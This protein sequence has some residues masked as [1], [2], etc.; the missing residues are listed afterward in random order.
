MGTENKK[1]ALFHRFN[2]DERGN[3][4]LMMALSTVVILSAV[5]AAVDFSVVSNADS[6]AQTI[7]DSSALAAAI[8]VKNHGSQ[9]SSKSEGPYGTYTAKELGYEVPGWVI[10]GAEGMKVDVTYDDNAK[11]AKVVVSGKTLPTFAQ[12]MGHDY[13]PFSAETTVKYYD[14]ELKDPA[15]IAL[16]LDNSGSMAWDD[17]PIIFRNNG[18]YYTPSDAVPRIDAL[19]TSAKNFMTSLDNLVGDQGLTQIG[20]RVLRTGMLA[21]NYQT[22]NTRTVHMK[23]G[24]LSNGNI[25]SMKASGG[26]NSAPPMDTASTWM[27]LEDAVHRLEHGKSPLKFVIFMTDGVNTSGNTGWVPDDTTGYWRK[28]SCSWWN[29][30]YNYYSERDYPTY[31]FAA[32]G[33]EEGENRLLSNDETLADCQRMKDAGV[34]VY[35]IGFA[36]ESGWYEENTYSN[37]SMQY[38]FIDEDTTNSAYAFLQGC[39]SSPKEFVKAENAESLEKAFE[40]IGNDIVQEIIR[41]SN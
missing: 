32:N 3:M 13:L 12:L 16:V 8:H 9:P 30:S 27:S 6:K 18:S 39:A 22:I 1:N 28:W 14:V 4:G 40:T 2:R 31:N 7:A 41:I 33:F 19:K 5:G 25:N 10:D 36:L 15:S 11:E 23:W 34:K 38:E 24:T 21:Y 17:K 35:T 37:G 29:C 26:T 20:N